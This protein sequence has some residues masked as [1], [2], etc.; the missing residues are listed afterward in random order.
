MM[1]LFSVKDRQIIMPPMFCKF[2]EVNLTLN[3]T[4][5]EISLIFF[6]FVFCN[7][8]IAPDPNKIE[9]IN[10]ASPPNIY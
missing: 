4:K 3:Q 5:C 8:G 7:K 9:A 2:A 1:S 10:K 6:G